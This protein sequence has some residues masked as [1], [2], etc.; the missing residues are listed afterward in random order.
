MGWERLG[1]SVNRSLTE[2]RVA[3]SHGRLGLA[4]GLGGQRVMTKR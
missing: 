1:Y 3:A 2:M 4:A